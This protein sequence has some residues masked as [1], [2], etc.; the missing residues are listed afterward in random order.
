MAGAFWPTG[1]ERVLSDKMSLSKTH[2]SLFHNFAQDQTCTREKREFPLHPFL[3]PGKTQ[4][5]EKMN[6]KFYTTN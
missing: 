3:P 2:F 6:P 4:P 5:S 1:F